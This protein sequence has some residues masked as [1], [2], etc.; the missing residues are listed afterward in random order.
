MDLLDTHEKSKN[1]N[2]KWIPLAKM[3][4]RLRGTFTCSTL[5][6]RESRP[7]YAN[8]QK[9]VKMLDTVESTVPPLTS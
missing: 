1:L 7:I 4:E 2:A 8:K 6:S 5:P 9:T 3:T